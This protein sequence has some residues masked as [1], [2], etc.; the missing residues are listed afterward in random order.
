MAFDHGIQKG[1]TI[2]KPSNGVVRQVSRYFVPPL[3]AEVRE[4]IGE[5][6][7]VLAVD[8]TG[9]TILLVLRSPDTSRQIAFGVPFCLVT[10]PALCSSMAQIMV[11]VGV[12]RLRCVPDQQR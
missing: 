4:N 1:D 5:G 10:V 11:R 3:A 6:H 8:T 9:W 2:V 7:S 12:Q